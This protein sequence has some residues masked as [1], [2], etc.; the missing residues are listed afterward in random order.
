MSQDALDALPF[1]LAALGAAALVSF[2]LTPLTIRYAGRLGAIDVPNDERRVH[3]QPIPRTG[4]LAVATAFVGVGALGLLA[5]QLLGVALPGRPVQTTEVAA[6]FVG[7]AVGAIFGYIDDRYQLKARWQ[8]VAQ[9]VLAG[10]ALA[11]GIL[12]VRIPNPFGDSIPLVDPA[13]GTAAAVAVTTIWIVGMLNSVNF[14]D[15]LDGLLA[16]ISLIAVTTLGVISLVSAPVQPVVAMLC[17]L[18]AGSL[19]GFLPYNFHPARVFI[20]TAGVFAVGYALA[21]LSVLGTAKLAVAL[22]V[23]GVPI[24]DTFWIIIRRVSQGRSPFDADRGHFHHRLLDLGL[25]HR[26]AVL[27]I[28]AICIVLAVLSV[29]LSGQGQISVFLIV[30]LLAGIV[31]YLLTRRAQDALDRRS[32]PDDSDDDDSNDIGTNGSGT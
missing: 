4:G 1:I 6:L 18:L 15:G 27:L 30:V 9:F 16:G 32:Y 22:L 11:G 29:V 31:L 28:Y 10:I 8:F 24:I 25:T 19:L 3:S 14:I 17:A 21:V 12:I 7:V 13:I 26:Q 23:L 2:L 5:N 20:G